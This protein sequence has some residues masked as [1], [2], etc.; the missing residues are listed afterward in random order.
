MKPFLLVMLLLAASAA[1]AV[2]PALG[3]PVLRMGKTPFSAEDGA[4]KRGADVAV[5]D[6]YTSSEDYLTL[7]SSPS[8]FMGMPFNLESD[9]G[10][11]PRISRIVVYMATVPATAQTFAALRARVQL[12]EG[13]SES[14]HP[15]FSSPTALVERTWT[16]VTLD[17]DSYYELTLTPDPPIPLSVLAS[18]GI[19]INY[20][21]DTGAGLQD[22]DTVNTLMRSGIVPLAV[23]SNPFVDQVGYINNDDGRADFNFN[24]N[25]ALNLGRPNQ[26]LAVELYA[27]DSLIDQDITD[28]AADPASP[29]FT[30]ESFTVSATGGVSGYPVTFSVDTTSAAVCAAGGTHGATIAILDAGTCLVH[31][32]QAGDATHRAAPR[33]SLPVRIMGLL[34]E[35]GGFEAGR[36]TPWLQ[37]STNFASPVCDAA[38]NVEQA[39]PRSGEFFVWLGGAENQ[40]EQ[41][42][43]Q[44]DGIIASGTRWLDFHLWWRSSVLAP[45]DPD[46]VFKVLIDGD[47]V[48]SLTPATAGLFAAHYAQASVDISAYADGDVHTLRL[49]GTFTANAEFT[50]VYVDDIG[51]RP[52]IVE[53]FAD[54]F[55][56]Q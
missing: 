11:N 49:E 46:A 48:F 4:G 45:P 32:D 8:T 56:A 38:C 52:I 34:V 33:Q 7:I 27:V 22:I 2:D 40:Y 14:G 23:G 42:F 3:R 21:A 15:V 9:V 35:D 12:W 31:A 47:T 18:H 50:S 29:L 16:N 10:P 17:G 1:D 41:G 44:Q 53:V 25:H 26:A 20:Q 30:D 13:W 5:F 6:S 54:G 28:F 55:E 51:I 39:E 24:W 43:V 37:G 36:A 19:A